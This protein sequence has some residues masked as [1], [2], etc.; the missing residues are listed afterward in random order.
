[1][2]FF[3]TKVWAWFDIALLK[4]SCI[5]SG[6]IAGAYCADFTRRYLFVIAGAALLLAIRPAAAYFRAESPESEH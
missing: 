1:M 5:L 4:W 3:K 2:K 6:I